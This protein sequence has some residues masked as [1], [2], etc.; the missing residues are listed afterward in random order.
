MRKKCFALLLG[1]CVVLQARDRPAWSVE[2]K[3]AVARPLDEITLGLAERDKILARW[4]PFEDPHA[5]V[6]SA[7]AF[8]LLM[9]SAVRQ[10]GP[11]LP[12]RL[13]LIRSSTINAFS[14]AGGQIY[15]NSGLASILGDD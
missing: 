6:V 10:A 8:G 14:T 12:H 1:A 2:A 9:G 11:K 4:P 15:V 5:N 13:T 7:K 3:S